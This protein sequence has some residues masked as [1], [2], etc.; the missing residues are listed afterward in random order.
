MKK[1]AFLLAVLA[2]LGL[3]TI[4]D[5]LWLKATWVIRDSRWQ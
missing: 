2:F 3:C 4:M 5:Y 1:G